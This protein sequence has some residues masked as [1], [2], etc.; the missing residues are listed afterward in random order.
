MP[1]AAILTKAILP[2][3]KTALSGFLAD[4][5]IRMAASLAYFTIFSLAPLLATPKGSWRKG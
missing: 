1:S 2:L 5:G 3:A 4:N